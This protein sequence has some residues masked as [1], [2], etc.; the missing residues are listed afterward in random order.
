[1]K[2]MFFLFQVPLHVPA[3]VR[4]LKTSYVYVKDVA[5]A[6]LLALNKPE[7]WNQAY[8]LALDETFT[9]QEL[10]ETIAKEIGVKVQFDVGEFN[11]FPSVTRGSIAIGK[12]KKYL[13]F[14][15]TKWETAL[16]VSFGLYNP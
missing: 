9:L 15:P 13:G 8:N 3:E 4:T 5:Q 12:A 7:S 6:V 16:K 11:V 10:L 2:A 1:M 14:V